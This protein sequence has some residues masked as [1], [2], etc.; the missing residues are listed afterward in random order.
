MW[1]LPGI[2]YSFSHFKFDF[3]FFDRRD[4]VTLGVCYQVVRQVTGVM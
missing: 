4:H 3:I 2:V 1:A